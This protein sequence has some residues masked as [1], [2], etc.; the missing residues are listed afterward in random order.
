M[1]MNNEDLLP[2]SSPSHSAKMTAPP[3]DDMSD[4]AARVADTFDSVD[5]LLAARAEAE[6]AEERSKAGGETPLPFVKE[7]R[8][9]AA[10]G[11]LPAKGGA[12]GLRNGSPWAARR[13]TTNLPQP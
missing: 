13:R 7:D 10:Q 6:E 8:R 4:F 2:L 3:D 12:D 11:S 1:I 5:L 9:A